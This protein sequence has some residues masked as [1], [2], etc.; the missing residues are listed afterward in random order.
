VAR[1]KAGGRAGGTWV[2]LARSKSV[3][4]S[5]A[6]RCA[7]GFRILRTESRRGGERVAVLRS[8]GRHGAAASAGAAPCSFAVP[9]GKAPTSLRQ[10]PVDEL[11]MR[12]IRY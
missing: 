6:K 1:G 7:S 8:H 10:A 12:P 11:T 5:S 4:F 2:F 3:A 9:V